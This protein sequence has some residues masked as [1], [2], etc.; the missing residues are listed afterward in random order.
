MDFRLS[1][2]QELIR[3]SAREFAE[4]ELAPH[5]REWDRAEE[6]DRALV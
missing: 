3:S 6:L 1:A 5:T 2:E 4:R